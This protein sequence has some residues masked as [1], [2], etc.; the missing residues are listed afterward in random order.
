MLFFLRS[1]L[2]TKMINITKIA[3]FHHLKK[4]FKS[5]LI[6]FILKACSFTEQ[7][8]YRI[9]ELY[10]CTVQPEKYDRSYFPAPI[11]FNFV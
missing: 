7:E 1:Y 8:P 10:R 11:Y 3:A 2:Q 5:K 4:I 6:I 9:S